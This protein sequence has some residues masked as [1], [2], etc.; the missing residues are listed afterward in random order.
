MAVRGMKP[1]CTAMKQRFLRR[2][3]RKTAQPI[4]TQ[5]FFNDLPKL[6]FIL[7]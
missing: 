6:A 3:E 2:G 1:H 7:L 4:V 5:P